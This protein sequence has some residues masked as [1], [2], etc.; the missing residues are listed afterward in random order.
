MKPLKIVVLMGGCSAEREVS[1][2]SGAA[3]TQALRAA[4]H[5]VV[6]IEVHGENLDEMSQLKPDVVFIALHGRFGEDGGVQAKL[7]DAGLAYVGSGV[8]ASRAGMDKMASKCFFQ[9][10]DVPT[11]E[12]RAVTA[13]ERWPLVREAADEIGLP[14]MVKPVRQ[15]SSLGVSLARTMDGVR[16]GLAEAFRYDAHAILER[17]IKGREFTVGILDEKPLPIVELLYPQSFFDFDAKYEAESTEFVTDLDLAR[18]VR[19]LVQ[20][21]ALRAHQAIGCAGFSRVDIILGRDSRPYVLEINT[22]PG[23]T[24]RSLFPLAA[25]AAGID[26]PD[27]CDHIVQN[28]L[29]NFVRE[30]R[31]FTEV[32]R[33]RV[34]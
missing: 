28:C 8:K 9:T 27:L 3:V 17:C 14:L 18:D 23:F 11:P 21:T 25:R 33:A 30:H 2:K 32:A 22:I 10:C 34:A 19:D 13:Q 16:R 1:L 4:G 7:E 20:R 24:E 15:G 6:P 5:A 31:P 29:R 26:F 12:F